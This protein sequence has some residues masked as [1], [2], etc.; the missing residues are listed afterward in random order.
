MASHL[1]CFVPPPPELLLR[2]TRL[3]CTFVAAN[4]PHRPSAH[5]AIAHTAAMHPGR[6]T[7]AM[8]WAWGG[9]NFFFFFLKEGHAYRRQR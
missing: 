6:L 4:R 3:L 2:M 9:V 7:C 1:S 8:P 5:G